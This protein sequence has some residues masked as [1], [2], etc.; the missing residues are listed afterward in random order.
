MIWLE[1]I[2]TAAGVLA[3][4][5]AT[6]ALMMPHCASHESLL[7]RPFISFQRVLNRRGAR[8]SFIGWPML[9]GMW[10]MLIAIAVL[11]LQQGIF[12]GGVLGPV[13]LAAAVGGATGNLL[14][15][16][17]RGAVVDFIAIGPWPVFNV[18][19]AAIVS[20]LGLVLLSIH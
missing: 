20:G 6:K 2:L 18:A 17:R 5:Q 4:D 11:V 16:L 13:G 15:R 8:A 14:D 9:V 10:A 7:S 1:P 12:G 3:M 19:D